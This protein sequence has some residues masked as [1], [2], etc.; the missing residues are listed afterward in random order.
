M[1]AEVKDQSL[2]MQQNLDILHS[3]VFQVRE[4]F[5]L[6]LLEFVT[7]SLSTALQGFADLYYSTCR[8]A[9]FSVG[10]AAKVSTK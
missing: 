10:E 2:Y 1:T 5:K 7:L 8:F 3:C 6:S 9:K 4:T